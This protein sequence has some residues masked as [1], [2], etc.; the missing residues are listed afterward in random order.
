MPALPPTSLLETIASRNVTLESTVALASNTTNSTNVENVVRV[1]C[2]W[3]VSGQYGPGSRVLYYVLVAACVF[4]RKAEWLR[5]ACLAAA[6][7]FPAVAAIHGIVLAAVH[8]D[9]A[10][11]MDIYGA[12]QFCSIGILAAPLSVRIS[13]TYFENPGRN[14]IF[15]WTGI[16]LAGLLSLTVEF[17][18]TTTSPCTHDESGNPI[19]IGDY[20]NFPYDNASCNLTCSIEKGP[21][22]PLRKDATDEIYVIP[23]PNRLA[24]DAVTLLA[25]A[26][27]IPA[28]LSLVSM[29][30]KILEINWKSRF[31][32]AKADELIEGTNGA[33][34]EG[35]SKVNSVVRLFLST[36]EIPLF[37]AAV[38]A[39]IIFGEWN[40]FTPQVQYQTEPINS[41]GQWAPLVGTLL[42]A[43]GSLYMLMAVDLEAVK[44]DA[45][46]K[47]STHHCN[48][49]RHHFNNDQDS[50]SPTRLGSSSFPDSEVAERT[51]DDTIAHSEHISISSSSMQESMNGGMV[52]NSSHSTAPPSLA[53]I[54]SS[55]CN[56]R[57]ET[58]TDLA[59][60]ET[61]PSET[62]IGNR[63]KVYNALL[64]AAEYL[65]TASEDR[66]DYSEFKHGKATDFPEIPAEDKRNPN[67]SQVRKAYNQ[68]HDE[69]EDASIRPSR[70]GSF[71][72]SI[73]SVSAS[74]RSTEGGSPTMT[75]AISAPHA[76][77]SRSSSP[78]P[79][80][81]GVGVRHSD[82]LPA[83]QSSFDVQ[84][85]EA[86]SS[87]G[88]TRGRTRQRRDTLEVPVFHP[89][90]S[91]AVQ[92][93]SPAASITTITN[94]QGSPAIVISHDLDAAS[95]ADIPVLD[96]PITQPAESEGA[97][98]P[99][100]SLP[101]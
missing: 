62:D 56:S 72:G 18:R 59:P 19:P 27:C 61:R 66:F 9:N 1:V 65:G 94:S 22:S 58:P 3:P 7:V 93:A 53:H 13:R 52:I 83:G 12:F 36:L 98:Q 10:V 37:S 41:I 23:A 79:S 91:R 81:H 14:I 46:M 70:A 50:N 35:M 96:L 21:W 28:V 67:L 74:R 55:S 76:L 34:D 26:C 64:S 97:P 75:R 92:P 30:N 11:D 73:I 77:P 17:F 101:P 85:S 48:C 99:K 2:A 84:S 80:I 60:T 90:S 68:H 15:L 5:N 95:I 54:R 25:A 31:G 42:A 78:S 86:S 88:Q 8:V 82:T 89:G 39:I 71:V 4:A 63:R 51:N 45:N 6:L 57:K 69:D 16:V 87:A 100:A 20:R 49:S 32:S 29:W 24:F 33:T 40:F 44:R 43:L 47:T 38:V